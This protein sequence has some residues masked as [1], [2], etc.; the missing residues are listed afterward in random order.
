MNPSRRRCLIF[1]SVFARV[2]FHWSCVSEQ[3]S[4]C[5]C[6]GLCSEG[7]ERLLK[8]MLL[9]EISWAKPPSFHQDSMSLGISELREKRSPRQ[10]L[11]LLK[12]VTQLR[13]T[14]QQKAAWFER[15]FCLNV[16]T[17]IAT[18]LTVNPFSPWN[19]LN[20]TFNS[21]SHRSLWNCGG[22]TPAWP[23][24]NLYILKLNSIKSGALQELKI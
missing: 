19:G 18:L 24:G 21:V 11:I 5:F 13:H 6:A 2:I 16:A 12:L 17:C 4:T 22:W 1:K 8:K 7:F 14:A 10:I 23:L 3:S 15:D 20:C 9:G